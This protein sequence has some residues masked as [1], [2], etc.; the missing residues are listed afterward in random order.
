MR[1]N[2]I[3]RMFIRKISAFPGKRTSTEI[4]GQS[5]VQC[6]HSEKF[7][8]VQ[9]YMFTPSFLNHVLKKV[10]FNNSKDSIVCFWRW[11]TYFHPCHRQI[12]SQFVQL[13]WNQKMTLG[14]QE[15]FGNF[16]H[17]VYLM[18]EESPLQSK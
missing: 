3:M 6:H 5:E 14:I 8:K 18:H 10:L 9:I 12:Y 13:V 4:R 2:M 16:Y 7:S 17:E 15:F 1:E 11:L